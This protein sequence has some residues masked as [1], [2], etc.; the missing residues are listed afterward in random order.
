MEAEGQMVVARELGG[1]E[2][3]ELLLDG[4][5]VSVA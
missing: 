3:E 2:N 5:V 4:N 1:G